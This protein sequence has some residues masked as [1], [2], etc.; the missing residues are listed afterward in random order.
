MLSA[1]GEAEAGGLVAPSGGS[2]KPG[3]AA[4]QPGR[5]WV[6]WARILYFFVVTFSPNVSGKFGQGS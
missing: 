2:S 4:P 1:T 5:R 3:P 6:L